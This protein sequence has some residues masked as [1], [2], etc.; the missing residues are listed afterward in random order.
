LM[1]L[2]VSLITN[3]SIF[4]YG[5]IYYNKQKSGENPAINQ[6][7]EEKSDHFW[8]WKIRDNT[9]IYILNINPLKPC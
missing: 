2:I 6:P 7:F 4:L 3:I 9:I 5:I 1:V 8:F